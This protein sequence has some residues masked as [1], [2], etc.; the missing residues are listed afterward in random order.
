MDGVRLVYD[1]TLKFDDS[2]VGRRAAR[3]RRSTLRLS[4]SA[5]AAAAA[6]GVCTVRVH[7]GGLCEWN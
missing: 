7:A 1:M 2:V 6:A 5:Q 3:G 4:S